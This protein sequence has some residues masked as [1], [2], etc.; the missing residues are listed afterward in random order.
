MIIGIDLGTTNS[1]AAIWRDGQAVLVP[2]AIGD[3]LTPSAV[4]IDD[5]GRMLIGMAARERQSTHPRDTVSAFKRYIGTQQTVTLGK[6]TYDAEELSALVL[7][8][9]KADAEAFAGESVTGAVITVPAYFN[10]RQRKA[11]RRA[12]ELAGL[13]V[14]RLV[15]EPTAAAL[16]FGIQTHE[17]EPFLVFDLGGGTFDVSIVEVFEGVVEVRASSGDNRLGGEDFNDK[18]IEIAR[19]ALDPER[20]LEGAD[21]VILHELLRAAAERARRKL[22]EAD[23]TEFSIVWQGESFTADVTSAAFEEAAAPLLQRLRDPVLRSLRDSNIR[24]ESLSE[25]VLVGGATRMPAVRRAITRMF[26]RFPNA[27]VHPDHAVALGAAVQAGLLARAE[28]LEEVRLTDVCPF[29]LGVDNA[30]PDG[31]GG[32]RTGLFSP[33]IDRNTTIPAS[34]VKYYGTVADNQRA[35]RFGIYQGE[36]REV[37]GNVKL[38]EVTLPIPPKPAGEVMVECRFTYD[39]SGIL[40]VDVSIPATGTTRNLVIIDE[41]DAMNEK[42]IAARRAELA[43]L[44]VHPRE[45]SENAAVLARAARCYEGFVAERRDLV[46]QWIGAF[47][48]ALGT[49]DPRTI[50]EARARLIEALDEIEGERFL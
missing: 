49:Q 47:E 9:L 2:N 25:I 4:S 10:D 33:I 27:T 15:N 28:A 13:K 6:R 7:R 29:T 44:K 12:G 38:G 48:G 43:A 42:Q 45:E 19:R 30:E 36:A 40:E 5:K 37:T 1:A 26:G 46:G 34:R 8:Q 16:A 20:K 23:E 3:L 21:P 35:L 24:V 18:V 22:S 17:Q 14:E 50:K 32:W 39:S 41:A 31:G 11:T